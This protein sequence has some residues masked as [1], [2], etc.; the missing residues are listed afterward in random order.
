MF[1]QCCARLQL[2][3]RAHPA[4]RTDLDLSPKAVRAIRARDEEA[5]DSFRGFISS[6]PHPGHLL[7]SQYAEEASRAMK[8]LALALQATMH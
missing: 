6:N 3:P 2:S 5:K 4:S 7:L 8:S 1:G